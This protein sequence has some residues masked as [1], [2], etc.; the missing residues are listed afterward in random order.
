MTTRVD[1]VGVCKQIIPIQQPEVS[2]KWI[3]TFWGTTKKCENKNGKILTFSIFK[4]PFNVWNWLAPQNNSTIQ[5]SDSVLQ[6]GIQK[7]WQKNEIIVTFLYCCKYWTDEDSDFLDDISPNLCRTN[8][9]FVMQLILEHYCPP[10]LYREPKNS[11][12]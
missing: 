10:S 4:K 5:F 7:E 12:E 6:L 3:I 9:S 1:L 8:I 2:Q 11:W